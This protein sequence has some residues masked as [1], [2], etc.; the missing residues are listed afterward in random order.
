MYYL[1]MDSSIDKIKKEADLNFERMGNITSES[2]KLSQFSQSQSQSQTVRK[3]SDYYS[4][5]MDTN[6]KIVQLSCKINGESYDLVVLNR[7]T[8]GK[9]CNMCNEMDKIPVL[10]KSDSI[11]SKNCNLMET[12]RCYNSNDIVDCDGFANKSC[13]AEKSIVDYNRFIINE[14]QSRVIDNSGK[15]SDQKFALKIYDETEESNSFAFSAKQAKINIENKITKVKE[16]RNVY[17]ICVPKIIGMLSANEDIYLEQVQEVSGKI[18][19]KMLFMLN[20]KDG[21]V[22]SKKYI[23]YAKDELCPTSDCKYTNCGSNVKFINLLSDP[24]HE[25]VLVFEAKIITIK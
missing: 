12:I 21:G 4:G 11:K 25:N 16:S 9:L 8:I 22:V 17:F 5:K 13:G 24:K 2:P 7:D 10:M 14:T 19:F 3:L 18:M 15:M 6:K 1:N 20:D 23:G